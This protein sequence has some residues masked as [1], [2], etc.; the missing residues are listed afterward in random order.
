MSAQSP[1]KARFT[2]HRDAN[3]LRWPAVRRQVR[4]RAGENLREGLSQEG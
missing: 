4:E 1:A 2:A 3:R